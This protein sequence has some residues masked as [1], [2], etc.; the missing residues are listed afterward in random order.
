MSKVQSQVMHLLIHAH[1]SVFLQTYTHTETKNGLI[2]YLAAYLIFLKRA[3]RLNSRS[4]SHTA[5][6]LDI[7]CYRALLCKTGSFHILAQ[8]YSYSWLITSH[9]AAHVRFLILSEHT[10]IYKSVWSTLSMLV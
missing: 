1:V 10:M 8:E 7:V 9:G 6:Q 4:Q 3:L 5:H 2:D